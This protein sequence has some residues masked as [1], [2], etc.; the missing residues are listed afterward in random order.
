MRKMELQEGKAGIEMWKYSCHKRKIPLR[1]L[2]KVDV[3]YG[4]VIKLNCKFLVLN[5]L[6]LSDGALIV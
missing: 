1:L 5:L 2:A 6:I 4:L 3:W